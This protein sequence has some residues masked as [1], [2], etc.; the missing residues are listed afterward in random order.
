MVDPSRLQIPFVSTWEG[1]MHF[2]KGVTF[3]NKKAVKCAL[4]IYAAKDNKNFTIRRSTKINCVPHVLT[5][6]ATSMLGHL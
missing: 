4:I 1:R 6:T 5:P 2:S 3:A